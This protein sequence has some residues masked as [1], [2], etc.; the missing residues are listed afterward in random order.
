MPSSLL[1][2]QSQQKDVAQLKAN[3]MVV[4]SNGDKVKTGSIGGD[5]GKIGSSRGDKPKIEA[6]R[7]ITDVSERSDRKEKATKKR[8][9]LSRLERKLGPKHIAL[10][11]ALKDVEPE[12]SH[13]RELASIIESLR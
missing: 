5:K 8:M 4:S 3:A 1:H 2:A 13:G 9:D 6:H 10:I 7:Q 11:Q 12:S